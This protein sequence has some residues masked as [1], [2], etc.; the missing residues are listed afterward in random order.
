[1]LREAIR[2]RRIQSSK[3]LYFIILMRLENIIILN[4]NK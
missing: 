3:M 4:I 2:R 1:M